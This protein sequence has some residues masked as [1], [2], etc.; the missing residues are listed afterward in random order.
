MPHDLGS[1]PLLE[2]PFA[3][4]FVCAEHRHVIYARCFTRACR[5]L[6]KKRAGLLQKG[7]GQTEL[8]LNDLYKLYY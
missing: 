2:V 3:S 8:S 6:L 1:H 5:T 7:N 4:R